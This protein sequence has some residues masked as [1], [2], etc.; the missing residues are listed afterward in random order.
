MSAGVYTDYFPGY[1]ATKGGRIS[2]REREREREERK[3]EEREGERERKR[4]RKK[5]GREK[6]RRICLDLSRHTYGGPVD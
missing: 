2:Q 6:F 1:V 5:R 3:R 4:E